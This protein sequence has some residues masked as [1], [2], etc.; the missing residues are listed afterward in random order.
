MNQIT[1]KQYRTIDLTILVALTILFEAIATAASTKWFVLQPVALS[2]GLALICIAMM[3]W[4]IQAALLAVADGMAFCF[5]SGA[6]TEQYV[7]YCF[8]N[9]FALLAMLI[10]RLFGKEQI[11]RSVPKLLLFGFIGYLGMAL[12]RWLV[13]LFFG[14][15]LTALLVYVT[16]DVMSLVFA[17]IVLLLFRK[18]DGLL[19]DQ[20]AYLLRL[21]K[22]K[23]EE[24]ESPVP[25]EEEF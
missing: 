21:D 9:L 12:G 6:T 7:I 13:S 18:T 14:G 23:K 20:K 25:E 2:I 3:R 16:T 22:E 4:G 24:A 5:I 1:F 17:E 10:I 19:E 11:R 15:D 8:G